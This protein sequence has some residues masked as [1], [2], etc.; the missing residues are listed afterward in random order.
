MLLYQILPFTLYGKE[1]HEMKS[2][3]L[4]DGSYCVSHIQDYFKYI[5]E[6]T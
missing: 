2:F 1:E 4:L 6:K 5:F 3:E